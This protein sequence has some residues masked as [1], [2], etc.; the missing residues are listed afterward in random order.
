MCSFTQKDTTVVRRNAPRSDGWR[1]RALL[2][3]CRS[4]FVYQSRNPVLLTR[5]DQRLLQHRNPKTCSALLSK[6]KFEV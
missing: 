5:T 1:H 2:I 6:Y 3:N 4:A